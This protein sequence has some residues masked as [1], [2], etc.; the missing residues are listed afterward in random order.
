LKK[1]KNK[2]NI[3]TVD[4]IRFLLENLGYNERDNLL[5]LYHSA[6]VKLEKIYKNKGFAKARKVLRNFDHTTVAKYDH[7]LGLKYK[8]FIENSKR[9]KEQKT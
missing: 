9:N 5:G 1:V 3:L 2:G 4:S 7:E 8:H 6:I